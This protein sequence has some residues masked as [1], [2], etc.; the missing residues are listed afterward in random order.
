MVKIK[1]FAKRDGA[2]FADHFKARGDVGVHAHPNIELILVT[3]GVCRSCIG[4]L[5]EISTV[6]QNVFCS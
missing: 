4:S 3:R 6:E 1:T 2:V 5:P